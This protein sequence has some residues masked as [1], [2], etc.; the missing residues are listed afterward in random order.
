M[1]ML[2]LEDLQVSVC[3]QVLLHKHVGLQ[4]AFNRLFEELCA[5]TLS[6]LDQETVADVVYA[7]ARIGYDDG[8]FVILSLYFVIPLAFSIWSI[9]L[10]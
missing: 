7:C 1:W 4:N 3:P 5:S 8:M 6:R 9:R 2:L 10:P